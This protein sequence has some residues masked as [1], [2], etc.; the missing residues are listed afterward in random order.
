MARMERT[1]PWKSFTMNKT[2]LVTLLSAALATSVFA[3]WEDTGVPTRP[4]SQAA[5]RPPAQAQRPQATA[6]P[7]RDASQSAVLK[8]PAA[9][10]PRR[11]P[12]SIRRSESP[13]SQVQRGVLPPDL[14]SVFL[15]AH[16]PTEHWYRLRYFFEGDA[17]AD[18]LVLNQSDGIAL[19]ELELHFDIWNSRNVLEGDLTI[20]TT[21]KLTCVVGDGG[22]FRN[23]P[24]YLAAIPLNV[25]WLWRFVNGWSIEIGTAPGIYSDIDALGSDM[26]GAPFRGCFYYAVQPQFSLKAGME[27]RPGWDL[28][29]MPIVG[30]GWQPTDN[31]LFELALPRSVINWKSD[32]FGLFGQV[33]WRSTTYNMSGDGNDPDD[34]SFEDWLASIG[35][36]FDITSSLRIQAEL[37]YAF[38]RTVTTEINGDK[39]EVE[40]D[41]MPYVGVM[42][43]AEF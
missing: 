42:I 11:P 25:D 8:R 4:A 35:A 20:G 33:E 34:I 21:P 32:G 30:V 3:G 6:R 38:G 12:E 19:F 13:S 9:S 43:G 36:S 5:P 24:D 27:V 15:D 7:A 10:Q 23:M 22:Y 39:D 14:Y 1:S 26:F 2:T 17:T 18:N 40:V 41:A 37:G 29:I 31:L 16:D 28:A